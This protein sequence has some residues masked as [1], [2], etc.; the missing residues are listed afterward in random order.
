MVP[1]HH[2]VISDTLHAAQTEQIIQAAR[3]TTPSRALYDEEEQGVKV[4]PS[5]GPG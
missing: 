4:G 3:E 1:D 5:M 2:S